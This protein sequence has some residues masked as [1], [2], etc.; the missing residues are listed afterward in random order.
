M[1]ARITVD[2]P[3]DA[4]RAAVRTRLDETLFVE[5][6]AGT[7]K[8]TV[9]VERIVELV[10]AEACGADAS[11]RGHHVHREGRG[12]AARPRAGRAR[13]ARRGPMP[14]RR[15]SATG[16]GR[17][18]KS[19]TRPRSAR[20]TRSR[21]ASSRPFRWKRGC[22][23]ASR[24]A[25]KC[26]RCSRSTIAGAAPATISSTIP[27]SN[28]RC[29]SCS[30]PGANLEHLRRVAEELD[31]N[32]DLLDRIELSP[33]LPVL[34][35]E[36]FLAELDALCAMGDHCSKDDRQVARLPRGHRGVRRPVARRHRRR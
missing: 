35:I 4:A 13:K 1:S 27:S 34:D 22:R 11:G 15:S 3:D 2:L 20:C 7:G 23:R 8:T 33:A 5:A 10:T 30:R 32:W 36:A 21:S 29:S 26:R 9:L 19:S 16:A 18:S 14:R 17:R 6:G 31:D 12:R 24:S 28:R 25:T